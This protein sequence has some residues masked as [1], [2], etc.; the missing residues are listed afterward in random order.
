[1]VIIQKE[2]KNG[3]LVKDLISKLIKIGKNFKN[4]QLS[5]EL[6]KWI[7]RTK[8]KYTNWKYGISD[9]D[10]YFINMNEFGGEEEKELEMRKSFYE[11]V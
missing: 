2:K 11:K 5:N 3:P 4:K 9:I 6:E 7:M 1:M 10:K 8:F